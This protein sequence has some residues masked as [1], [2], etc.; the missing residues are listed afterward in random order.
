MSS[1]RI[2]LMLQLTAK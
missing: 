2:F 1:D